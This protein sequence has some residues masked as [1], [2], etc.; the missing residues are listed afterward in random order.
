[1]CGW[2]LDHENFICEIFFEQNLAKLN[3]YTTNNLGYTVHYR[4]GILSS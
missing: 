3:I 1:M 2:Q 4:S